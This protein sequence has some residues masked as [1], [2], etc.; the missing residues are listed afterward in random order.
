M[1]RDLN[2]C[3]FIGRLGKDVEIRYMPSGKAV[4]TF[5]IACSDDYKDKSTGES[6]EQTNWIPVVVFDRLAEVAGKYLMKGSQ[7]YVS[8]EFQ[9]R[10]WKDNDG[11]DRYKSEIVVNNLQML[12]GRANQQQAAQQSK[13]VQQNQAELSEFDDEIPF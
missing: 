5:N 6:V 4:A 13:P 7:V 1:A 11:N 9:T 12:G 10:K 3:A 2:N 8:G